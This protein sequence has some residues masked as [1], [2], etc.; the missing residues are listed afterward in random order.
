MLVYHTTKLFVAA[1]P[2]R[3]SFRTRAYSE[4]WGS[5]SRYLST[6]EAE[7]DALE[8]GDKFSSYQSY[9]SWIHGMVGLPLGEVLAQ[10][11]VQA[12][13]WK[14]TFTRDGMRVA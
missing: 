6:I 9:Y 5:I 1:R 8:N 3:F 10:F 12:P 4:S 7:I 14:A 13:L 2:E 11:D